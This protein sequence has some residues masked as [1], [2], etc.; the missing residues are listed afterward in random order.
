MLGQKEKSSHKHDFVR[1]VQ[2]LH[3]GVRFFRTMYYGLHMGKTW[4]DCCSPHWVCFCFPWC[5]WYFEINVEKID[6]NVGKAK[7][8]HDRIN[9]F[10]SHQCLYLYKYVDQKCW[11]PWRGSTQARNPPWH[12]NSGH[13]S[14]EV[15]N[16]YQL[17]HKKSWWPPFF[18]FKK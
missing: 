11:L 16:G 18:Y 12:W 9:R 10:K 3:F 1:P 15:Q 14:P 13:T 8:K 5:Q 17:Q 2:W 7:F 4:F 6:K